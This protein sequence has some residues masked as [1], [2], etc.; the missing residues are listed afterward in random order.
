MPELMSP[1]GP[2]TT[3]GNDPSCRGTREPGERATIAPVRESPG[4]PDRAAFHFPALLRRIFRGLLL[5]PFVALG[6][7]FL[8]SV[9][10]PIL[11]VVLALLLLGLAPFLVVGLGFLAT[12]EVGLPRDDLVRGGSLPN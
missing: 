8:M 2:L 1:Q 11:I 9:L 5:L 12:E 4:K 10:F 3:V 7:V 6:L